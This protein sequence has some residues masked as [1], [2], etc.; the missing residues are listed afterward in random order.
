[1]YAEGIRERVGPPEPRERDGE[2]GAKSRVFFFGGGGQ[3][4]NK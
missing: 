2:G 1:M 3:G 4:L